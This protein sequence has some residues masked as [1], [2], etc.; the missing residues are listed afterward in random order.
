MVTLGSSTLGTTR[1]LAVVR[2][3]P[4]VYTTFYRVNHRVL[5]FLIVIIPWHPHHCC[6]ISPFLGDVTHSDSQKPF[7]ARTSI[8][9]NPLDRRIWQHNLFRHPNKVSYFAKI[10]D[11][12]GWQL[13]G[14][15]GLKTIR[16]GSV[17]TDVS[18]QR[19][20][21]DHYERTRYLASMSI[22]LFGMHM[23]VWVKM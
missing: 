22:G 14:E 10:G 6:Q 7:F 1:L 12:H 3:L 18:Y 15:M 17:T 11:T 2:G 19:H 4:S 5:L 23:P 13:N 9:R 20:K 21:F 16:S 8:P